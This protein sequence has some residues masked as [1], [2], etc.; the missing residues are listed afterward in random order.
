MTILAEAGDLRRFGHH[1]QFLKYCGFDLAK[2][3]SGTQRG[4]EPHRPNTT[5]STPG[6]LRCRP[7]EAQIEPSWRSQTRWPV[8]S[9]RCL[10]PASRIRKQCSSRRHYDALMN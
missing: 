2:I 10:Q 6:L 5:E 7:G 9:G 4:R 3:Q 1:R 8:S